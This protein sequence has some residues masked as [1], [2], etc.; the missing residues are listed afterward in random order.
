VKLLDISS[1]IHSTPT[2][3]AVLTD[4]THILLS[5]LPICNKFNCI[6]YK[7]VHNDLISSSILETGETRPATTAVATTNV[8][9]A[10]NRLPCFLM[11]TSLTGQFQDISRYSVF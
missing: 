10:I 8:K 3:A 9:L 5:V 4:N 11:D 6:H 1:N 7:N 2:D